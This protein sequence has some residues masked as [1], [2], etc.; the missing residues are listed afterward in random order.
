MAWPCLEKMEMTHVARRISNVPGP[1]AVAAP[2]DATEKPLIGWSV[3]VFVRILGIHQHTACHVYRA[4]AMPRTA[5]DLMRR[6]NIA[7]LV[8]NKERDGLGACRF[9]ERSDGLHQNFTVA[10]PPGV[11]HAQTFIALDLRSA[12]RLSQVARDRKAAEGRSQHH[13]GRAPLRIGNMLAKFQ[14]GERSHSRKAE[15]YGDTRRRVTRGEI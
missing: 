4:A 11:Q 8:D 6:G 5:G 2:V 10:Q 14:I 7:S 9:L 15:R 12:P 13:I 3:F 1:P